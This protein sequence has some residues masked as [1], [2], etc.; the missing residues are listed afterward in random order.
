MC[1]GLESSTLK[2]LKPIISKKKGLVLW[3]EDEKLLA[4]RIKAV[5][6]FIEKI[7]VARPKPLARKK[8]VQRGPYFNVG[9]I[10]T[11]ELDNGLKTAAIVETSN[12]IGVDGD[13]TLVFVDL[14]QKAISKA[15][16]LKADIM[17]FDC[18]GESKY[19]RGYFHAIFSARNMSK[20]IQRAS[21]IGEVSLKKQMMLAVG[22]RIGSWNKISGL[23]QEQQEFLQRSKSERPYKVTV[24]HYL[25]KDE[26]L[27]MQLIEWD[28]KVFMEKMK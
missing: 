21:K 14:M 28:K 7:Q 2:K 23:F 12:K 9:D 24:Q 6:D 4:K 26:K 13:N 10:I 15:D 20:Q 3:S 17:Y 19:Y 5:E 22:T 16:V 1:G 18:G 25:N 27:E 11:I 8:I